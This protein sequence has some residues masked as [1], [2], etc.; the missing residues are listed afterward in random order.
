MAREAALAVG[1]GAAAGLL[2]LS[3]L[4]GSPVAMVLVNLTQLPLF[5]AGLMLGPHAAA[6]AGAAGA[7][8]TLTATSLNGALLFTLGYAAPVVL[9]SWQALRWRA[10]EAGAVWWYPPG[11]LI[12]WLVGAA[13]ASIGVGALLTLGHEGGYEGAVRAVIDQQLALFVGAGERNGQMAA[14]MAAIFPGIGA[15]TW[16][17]LTAANGAIAQR[18]LVWWRKNRR[19]TPDIVEVELPRWIGAAF[20]LA[21]AAAL[22]LP[23]TSGYL[24]RNALPVFAIAFFVAGLAVVHAAARRFSASGP[25][26]GLAYVLILFMSPVTM[27]VAALGLIEQWAGL[28]RRL[29]PGKGE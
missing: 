5:L 18:L 27:A 29:G 21:L 16:I 25:I 19:P 11:R 22:L 2:F 7:L 23:G 28:R 4:S 12:A 20:I 15:A 6:I 14:A 9:V 1:F 3:L 10:D 17:F 24:G 13:L 8:G 26:L